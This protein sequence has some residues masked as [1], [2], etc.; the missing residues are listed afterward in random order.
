MPWQELALRT[1][2]SLVGVSVTLWIYV[3]ALCLIG[4]HFNGVRKI[5]ASLVIYLLVAAAVGA[6]L[7][8]VLG[9]APDTPTRK[10]V[11]F[12]ACVLLSWA[13]V[14][15]PGIIYLRRRLPMLRAMGYFSS[16]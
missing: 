2:A 9:A 4:V 10:T 6:A 5:A 14:S 1:G 8:Y 11:P 16:K 13:I 15:A 7:L 12:M 3:H